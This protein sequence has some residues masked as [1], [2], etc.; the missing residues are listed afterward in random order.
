MS[1]RL[2]TQ[3]KPIVALVAFASA[4]LGFRASHQVGRE[5]TLNRVSNQRFR[6]RLVPDAQRFWLELNIR[7]RELRFHDLLDFD[8]GWGRGRGC[9]DGS[10]RV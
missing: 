9:V 1:N 2:P 8:W 5:H 7:C 4:R 3:T 6:N 10:H